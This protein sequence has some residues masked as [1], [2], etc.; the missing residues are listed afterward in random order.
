[1]LIIAVICAGLSISVLFIFLHNDDLQETTIY[2][3][4]FTTLSVPEGMVLIPAG[5]FKMGI[6]YPDASPND[7]QP[8][9]T[10]RVD[11]FFIGDSTHYLKVGASVS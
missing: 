1:M 10:V 7:E 5:E 4:E 6:N 11:A 9:Y 3:H 2:N 8:V